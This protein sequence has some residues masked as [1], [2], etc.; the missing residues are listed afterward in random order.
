[1]S[2]TYGIIFFLL[3]C[4]S[5]YTIKT[6]KIADYLK[7]HNLTDAEFARKIGVTRAMVGRYRKGTAIPEIVTALRIEKA[8][9]KEV[10]A[11]DLIGIEEV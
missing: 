8:T 7:E 11:V 2:H 5:G 1:M 9:G 3:W 10:R 6:M 4:I